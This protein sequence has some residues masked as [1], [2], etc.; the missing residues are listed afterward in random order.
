MEKKKATCYNC[1]WSDKC[2]ENKKCEDYTPLDDS[3]DAEIT[4]YKQALRESQE[5]YIADIV[6][7]E[8]EG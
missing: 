1:Y 8:F 5:A 7:R 4:Y 2:S 6:I 3:M